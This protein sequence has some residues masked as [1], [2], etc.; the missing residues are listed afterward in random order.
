MQKSLA[1]AADPSPD[2][3][4]VLEDDVKPVAPVAKPPAARPSLQ[5]R[6]ARRAAGSRGPITPAP[7]QAAAARVGARTE[8]PR[9][10]E[11]AD[12]SADSR[13]SGNPRTDLRPRTPA[14]CRSA[15]TSR[16]PRRASGPRG[17]GDPRRPPR[18]R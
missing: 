15:D 6:R 9:S 14:R 5:A 10:A 3:R 1:G 16:S 12:G 2:A 18:R 8:A 13:A 11:E 17:D 7:G 4:V